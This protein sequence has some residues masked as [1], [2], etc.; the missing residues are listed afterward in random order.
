MMVL[1]PLAVLSLVLEYGF[2][3]SSSVTTLFQAFDL[4]VLAVFVLSQIVKLLRAPHRGRYIRE[5]RIEF[6]FTVFLIVL[7]ASYPLARG[8]DE[9]LLRFFRVGSMSSL[10]II[11]AQTI[12]LIDTLSTV[13]RLSRKISTKHISPARLFL[14]SFVLLIMLGALLLSLPRAST[15]GISLVDALFTSTSAV[16]VTGLIVVDT[17]TAFTPFGQLVILLLIQ[18][19]GLGLMTF[20]TFFVLFSG[21][22]SIRERVLMQDLLNRESLGQVRNALI[23]IVG[24]TLLFEAAG[25]VLLY[26]SWGDGVFATQNERIVSSIFHSVSAFCNAGFSLFSTNL[27][28]P[29]VAMNPAVNAIVASLIVF[30]GLGFIVIMNLFT[31]RWYG[32]KA[33]RLRTRL[34]A[35]TKLVLAT[36]AVLIAGGAVMFLAL[37]WNGALAQLTAPEKLMAAVF[38][39]ISTRT[40]G[41][42]TIDIG[43]IGAPASLL[44]ILLMFIGASPGSTGGGIKTTTAALIFLAAINVVRGREK[45]HIAH[46]SVD[47]SV[48]SRALATMIFMMALLACSL[49]LLTIFEQKPLVDVFFECVSAIGTVGLSRGITGSLTGASK[50]VLVFTMLIGRVGPLTM[51]MALVHSEPTQRFDYPS[52]QVVV[53]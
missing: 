7:L 25:A 37:E 41:F 15:H 31:V 21:R 29:G 5:R 19:G 13:L 12:I 34:T 47:R 32:R 46:R 28:G 30:G 43:R 40:A 36:T 2:Y 53:G 49:F 24:M 8:A 51:M 20:T 27:G 22:L 6:F 52:E 35:H 17:A 42:N 48:V 18:I 45:I 23:G 11:V 33:A 38:Q 26:L 3:F 39:S 44:F 1:L 14:A 16:C 4:L 50:I 10:Y 9:G